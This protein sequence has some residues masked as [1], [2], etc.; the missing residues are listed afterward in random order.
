MTIEAREFNM[1]AVAELLVS[2]DLAT[3]QAQETE[4]A[5]KVLAGTPV[6]DYPNYTAATELMKAEKKLAGISLQD[7]ILFC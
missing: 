4:F 3:S 1:E 6:K 7:K 5:R 2:E